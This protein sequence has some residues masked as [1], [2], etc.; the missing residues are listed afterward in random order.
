MYLTCDSLGDL[1]PVLPFGAQ[2]AYST[3]TV[4]PPLSTEN[5]A[6]SLTV[7]AQAADASDISIVAADEIES[8]GENNWAGGAQGAALFFS[9][10]VLAVGTACYGCCCVALVA[11]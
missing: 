2:L 1:Y 8:N 9:L 4:T 7:V 5:G 6:E 3:L 10:L 11:R